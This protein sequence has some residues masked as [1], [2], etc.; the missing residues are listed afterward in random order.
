MLVAGLGLYAQTAVEPSGSGTE[1]DPYQIATLGNLY[2]LKVM[3][4]T[5]YSIQTADIDASETATWNSDGQGGYY[6]WPVGTCYGNY[7]GQGYIIDN[8]YINRSSTSNVGLFGNAFNTQSGVNTKEITNVHLTNVNIT[9]GSNTGALVGSSYKYDINECSVSGTVTGMSYAGGLVGRFQTEY[10]TNVTIQECY[11]SASVTS[12]MYGGGLIGAS[13][14][15]SI[16]RPQVI[17]SY[18][19]GAVSGTGAGGLVGDAT[20]SDY[21]YCYSTATVASSGAGG[22]AYSCDASGG[23]GGGE[24]GSTNT[25]CFFNTDI[26][27]NGIVNYGT[28]FNFIMSLFNGAKTSAQLKTQTTYTAVGWDFTS[29]WTIDGSLNSGYPYLQSNPSEDALPITLENFTAEYKQGK[30]E[31]NWVTESEE[32]NARFLIYRN[33]D[34]IAMIDGAGTTT[35]PHYYSYCDTDVVPGMT[36]VY[37]LG[38]V[39]YANEL[40]IHHDHAVMITV[41]EQDIPQVFALNANYPNPFN[42]STMIPFAITSNENVSLNIYDM[43]GKLIKTL[44]NGNIPAG[45][46]EILWDGKDN[47]GKAVNSGMY[48]SRLLAGEQSD[49]QKMLMVK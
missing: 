43:N 19:H 42:P 35:E 27:A 34:V 37:K 8:L 14:G 4:F 11:S 49:S 48:I 25:G 40:V 3:G 30:V 32:N 41:S 1:V 2:W 17:N 20:K 38:D 36:Y 26:T 13:I 39:S 29:T 15:A 6:G 5:G 12:Y 21:Y 18:T 47:A 45:Y 28:N 44:I 23:E 46:H 33:D 22:F 31:I 16:G 7:D 10:G 9:G 24:G